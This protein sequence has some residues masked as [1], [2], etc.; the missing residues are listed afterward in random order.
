ME[1]AEKHMNE[2]MRQFENAAEDCSNVA[3]TYLQP[4]SMDIDHMPD[5]ARLD[6]PKRPP[7]P[8]VS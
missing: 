6:K 8:E 2:G 3:E 7:V 4:L 5:Y 1:S